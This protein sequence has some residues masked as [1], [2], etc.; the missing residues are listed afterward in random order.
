LISI[1]QSNHHEGDARSK[2]ADER[3]TNS[4]QECGSRAEEAHPKDEESSVIDF[5]YID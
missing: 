4:G 2:E 3:W 5:P 1:C